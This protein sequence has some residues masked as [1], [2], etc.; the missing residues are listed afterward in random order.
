MLYATH[1]SK[2][3]KDSLR[4]GMRKKQLTDWI[5]ISTDYAIIRSYIRLSIINLQSNTTPD[6]GISQN[7]QVNL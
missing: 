1:D 5:Y 7:I 3:I 6:D 2:K 4:F